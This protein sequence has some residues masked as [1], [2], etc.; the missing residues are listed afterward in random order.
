[1]Y[2][3]TKQELHTI[4]KISL[5]FS[6]RMS[7]VFMILPVLHIFAGALHA[8]NDHL[9]G[10]AIGIYGVMQII[11]QIP[12]GIMSDKIGHKYAIVIGLIIFTIGNEIAALT[13]NIWGLIA[14]RALQG[15]GAISGSLIALLLNSIQK[16][17]RIQAMAILG[18]NIGI[19]FAISIILSPIITNNF[20]LYGLFQ[21]IT[22][23][24]IVSIILAYYVIEST[25]T[26]NVHNYKNNTTNTNISTTFQELK[27]ILK[28][29]QLMKLNIG[30]FCL[31]TMLMLN[32][33]ILPKVMIHLKFMPN[34]HWKI[35]SIFFI[36][37][38]CIILPCLFCGKIKDFIKQILILCTS[39]LFISELIMLIN[40]Y[41]RWFFLFGIQ[42]F[43]IAFNL[44]ET[45]LPSLIHQTSPQKYRSTTISIYSIGQFTG[46]SFGSIIG[47][48]LVEKQGIPIILFFALI[49]S[50]IFI[51]INNA[52]INNPHKN[53]SI[54]KN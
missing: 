38:A 29:K 41:H 49:I 52:Y 20:G 12:F 36:V 33:T 9:I 48:F 51:I 19:T 4:A 39:I 3:I 6:I 42:L 10:I 30:V 50:I 1:M 37:S 25:S 35:Y 24:G 54:N 43:F 14:G 28:N 23:L 17:H 5:I 34:I 11:F 53:H 31:H 45:I 18:I 40:I 13:N 8:S 7:G 22:L 16:Q 21:S 15:S 44:L 27:K 46:I 47:G 2:K 32:F 26:V